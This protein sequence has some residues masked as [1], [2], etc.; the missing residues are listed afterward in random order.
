M[1]W[2]CNNKYFI[3]IVCLDAKYY[4]AIK[5]KRLPLIPSKFAYLLEYI[6]ILYIK[7]NLNMPIYD[8]YFCATLLISSNEYIIYGM[9]KT[10]GLSYVWQFRKHKGGKSSKNY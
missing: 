1:D 8:K 4:N 2:E 6:T 9:K 10:L 5:L 3:N 7:Q